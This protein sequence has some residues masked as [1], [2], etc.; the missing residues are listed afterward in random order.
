MQ[1][2]IYLFFNTFSALSYNVIC[3][4]EQK[5]CVLVL[6]QKHIFSFRQNNLPK[7]TKRTKF[8]K[9]WLKQNHV[10]RFIKGSIQQKLMWVK[11]GVIRWVWA[12]DCGALDI[13]FLF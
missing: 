4:V 8:A 6:S 3:R 1:R 9:K 2:F 10:C 13:I 11:T 5:I 12:L 7:V